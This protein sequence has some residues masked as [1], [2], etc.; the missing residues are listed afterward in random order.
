MGIPKKIK[1]TD[2]VI[3]HFSYTPDRQVF[4]D[5]DA[6]VIA[7][8]E[9]NLRSYLQEMLGDDSR[10]IIKKTRYGEIIEGLRQ[11]GAYAFDEEAY[12]RFEQCC[13]SNEIEIPLSDKPSSSDKS[14]QLSFVRVQFVEL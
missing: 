9:E 2:K 6:C 5:D 12:H 8:S 1:R 11:G 10:D 7:G 13:N 4:C 14:A 3:G